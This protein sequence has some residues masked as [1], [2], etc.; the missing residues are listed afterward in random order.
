MRSKKSL[1]SVFTM[2]AALLL[3]F[4][5]FIMLDSPKTAVAKPT[6]IVVEVEYFFLHDID[7]VVEYKNDWWEIT[8]KLLQRSSE[9]GIVY[10]WYRLTRPHNK[11]VEH[12]WVWAYTI[13]AESGTTGGDGENDPPPPPDCPNPPC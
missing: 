8:A 5:A 3:L 10:P 13:D 2:L 11:K 7:D 4:S 12:V 9:N 1:K 6:T